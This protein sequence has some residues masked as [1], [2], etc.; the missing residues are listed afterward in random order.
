MKHYL[1]FK[2]CMP[3]INKVYIRRENV[4]ATYA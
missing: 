4:N 2:K 3:G 1:I